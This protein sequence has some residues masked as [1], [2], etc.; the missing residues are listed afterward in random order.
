MWHLRCN[1][2]KEA[3]TTNDKVTSAGADGLYV[4]H[5]V[6]RRVVNHVKYVGSMS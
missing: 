6:I 1:N 4:S 5:K 3:A 2:P